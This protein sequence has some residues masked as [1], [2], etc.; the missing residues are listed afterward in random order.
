VRAIE[1]PRDQLASLGMSPDRT[2][3]GGIPLADLDRSFSKRIDEMRD[4]GQARLL[5]E[6][7]LVTV[8]GRS[9]SFNIGGEIPV[10]VTAIDGTSTVAY[11][12]FGTR[13]DLLPTLLRNGRIRV[14]FNSEIR[15]AEQAALEDETS[16]PSF[17]ANAVKT[18]LDLKD[19]ETVVL[20]VHSAGVRNQGSE[21]SLLIL[22]TVEKAKSR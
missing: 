17:R 10:P 19:G 8:S 18:E 22:A 16:M 4:A 1:V 20:C 9:T 3:S 2:A 14:E 13:I 15:A 11:R 12:E 5:A 21:A 6:P 7:I